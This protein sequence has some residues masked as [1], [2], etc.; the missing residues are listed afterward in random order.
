MAQ[1][2]KKMSIKS[3]A[4]VGGGIMGVGIIHTISNFERYWPSA[5]L[6]RKVKAGHFGKKVGKG[7]FSTIACEP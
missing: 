4:V 7:F 5:L 3:V 1:M 2:Q 6:R